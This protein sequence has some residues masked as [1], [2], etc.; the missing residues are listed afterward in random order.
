MIYII[1]IN[2]QDAILMAKILDMK[3]KKKLVNDTPNIKVP[4][5]SSTTNVLLKYN[6]QWTLMNNEAV[7]G[8]KLQSIKKY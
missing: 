2:M 5:V 8:L 4:Q 7:V 1:V 3:A 6:P